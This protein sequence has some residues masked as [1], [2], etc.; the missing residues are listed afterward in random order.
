M[1]LVLDT[2]V[3]VA[4][5]R[6]QRG[7]SR[8]LLEAAL[9]SRFTCLLS[10][11]LTLEYEAVLTRAEHLRHA[12]VSVAEVHIVLDALVAVAEPVRIAYQWRPLVTDRDDEMVLEAALNGGADAIV[13][14]NVRDFRPSGTSGLP[15]ILTPGEAWRKVDLYETK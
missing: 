5:I 9:D 7:A 12:G 8:L 11:A 14:M 10:V 2:S 3:L 13:T 6:S 15:A 4:A 1:R